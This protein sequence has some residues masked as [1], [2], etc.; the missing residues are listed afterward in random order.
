MQGSSRLE[1]ILDIFQ[2][3]IETGGS[4]KTAEL[5]VSASA[6][7]LS[8]GLAVLSVLVGDEPFVVLD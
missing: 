7:G 6:T 5:L 4:L 2:T 8:G 3:Q 1:E